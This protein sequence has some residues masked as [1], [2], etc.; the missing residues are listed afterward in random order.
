MANDVIAPPISFFEDEVRD[1]FLIPSMM[2]RMWAYNIKS[3]K[4]LEQECEKRGVNCSAIFG[5][6]LGAMLMWRCCGTST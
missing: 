2:K 1:G 6:L 3:Y 5:S 4:T